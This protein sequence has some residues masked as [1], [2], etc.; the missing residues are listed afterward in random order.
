MDLSRGILLRTCYVISEVR[1]I[2]DLLP[3]GEVTPGWTISRINVPREHRGKGYGSQLLTQILADADKENAELWL[4]VSPS[5]GLSYSQL[6][7]WY[8]R[9]GFS[10]SNY[11]YLVRR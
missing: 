5:D 11:G 1:A 2:A 7:T 6:V 3:P 10:E 8:E 9:Y 4:E